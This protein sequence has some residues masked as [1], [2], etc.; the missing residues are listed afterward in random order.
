GAGGIFL[1]SRFVCEASYTKA[2]LLYG[3]TE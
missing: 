3:Q 2:D 1:W